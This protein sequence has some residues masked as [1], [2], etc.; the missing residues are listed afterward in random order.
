ML[1]QSCNVQ[2]NKFRQTLEILLS[3][4]QGNKD[5]SL[6]FSFYA[7]NAYYLYV[8]CCSENLK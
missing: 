8:R 7:N 4:L 3:A 6:T 5:Q 1:K 2:A